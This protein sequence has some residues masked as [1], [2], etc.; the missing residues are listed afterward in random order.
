[1]A[2]FIQGMIQNKIQDVAQGVAMYA[3]TTGGRVVGDVVISA[4]DLI[5]ASGRSVGDGIEGYIDRY[6]NWIRSY[7]NGV[8]TATAASDAPK[9]SRPVFQTKPFPTKEFPTKALKAL[10]APNKPNVKALPAPG[11]TKGANKRAR[12]QQ[13]RSNTDTKAIEAPAPKKGLPSSGVKKALPAPRTATNAAQGLSKGQLAKLRGIKLNEEKEKKKN[14]SP[15]AALP[16]PANGGALGKPTVNRTPRKAAAGGD[17]AGK[18]NI[19]P[20]SNAAKSVAGDGKAATKGAGGEANKENAQPTAPKPMYNANNNKSPVPFSARTPD[21]KVKIS[22]ASRPTKATT[23]LTNGVGAGA[24]QGAGAVGGAAKA[25]TGAV[26]KGVGA[27][28]GGYD[29]LADRGGPPKSENGGVDFMKMYTAQSKKGA[30]SVA[31]SVKGGNGG[32][33]NGNKGGEQRAESLKFDFF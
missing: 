13:K 1:M 32:K 18:G 2:G 26:N 8:T 5:E 33:A 4:G 19:K 23:N 17:A 21:G 28:K 20:T 22:S 25:G 7:G 29:F 24:K 27:A 3:V 10:P 11:P 9:G 6:G 16:A 15:I 12:P 30:G 31:G 14:A